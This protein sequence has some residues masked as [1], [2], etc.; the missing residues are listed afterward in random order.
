MHQYVRSYVLY[1][2]SLKQK[3]YT[4]SHKVMLN[5]KCN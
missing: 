5:I 1:K 3:N 2:S 4:Y